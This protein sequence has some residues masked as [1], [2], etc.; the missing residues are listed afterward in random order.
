MVHVGVARSSP[1]IA[2]GSTKDYTV[3]AGGS[4]KDC[5]DPPLVIA[6]G[7]MKDYTDLP[8]IIA[9]GS[10]TDCTDLPLV[11][12]WRFKERLIRSSP[13]LEVQRKVIQIFT[14]L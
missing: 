12:S 2:G 14:W 1:S 6:G 3:I 7:S 9:R 4:T 10:I 5:T 13:S 11:I 8:L